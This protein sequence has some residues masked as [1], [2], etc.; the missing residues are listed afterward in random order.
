MAAINDTK[1]S[2]PQKDRPCGKGVHGSFRVPREFKSY[3]LRT[4]SSLASRRRRRPTRYQRRPS[5]RLSGEW[6]T[7]IGFEMGALFEVAGAA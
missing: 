4:V 2:R 5:I 1:P 6:L 3:R 7:R